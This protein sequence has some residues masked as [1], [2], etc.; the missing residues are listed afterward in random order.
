MSELYDQVQRFREIE[1]VHTQI[2]G[3]M[4][5]PHQTTRGAV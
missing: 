1:A 4:K 3:R 5:F 2:S